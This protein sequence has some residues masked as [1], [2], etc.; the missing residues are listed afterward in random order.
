MRWHKKLFLGESIAPRWKKVKWKIMHNAGQ[1]SVYVLAL[2]AN[3][4]NILDI[5]PAWELLQKQYP[6]ENLYIIGLAGNYE[7][8]LEVT[9]SIIQKVYAKTNGFDVKG[10]IKNQSKSC[11][12]TCK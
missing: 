5:I 8:A 7:E 1:L 3:P 11:A 2:P 4:S 12:K 10:Y 6:K 9:V